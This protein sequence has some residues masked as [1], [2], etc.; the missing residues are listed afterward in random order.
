MDV[1]NFFDTQQKRNLL[2]L[3]ADNLFSKFSDSLTAIT[4]SGAN[5]WQAI[6]QQAPGTGSVRVLSN[7]SIAANEF[8]LFAGGRDLPG[9]QIGEGGAGGATSSGTIAWLQTVRGRGQAGALTNPPTDFAP[10]GGYVAFDNRTNW[11]FGTDIAAIQPTQQDFLTTATHELMHAMGFG[12]APSWNAWVS[13][14][15]F[16]G[17]QAVAAHD[18]GGAVPLDADLQHWRTGLTDGGVET[19]MDPDTSGGARKLPTRLDLAS[20]DDMGWELITPTIRVTGDHIYGDNGSY[21]ASIQVTGS[22]LGTIAVPTTIAITNVVPTLI[23]RSDRTQ[24]QD[25]EFSIIDI[26]SFSDPGFD[27]STAPTPTVETFTYRIDWGDGTPADTGTATVDRKGAVNLATLGSFD[28]RHIYENIGRYKV[29]VTVTDDDRGSNTDEFFIDVVGNPEISISLDRTS[30][31]ENAGTNAATLTVR[32]SGFDRSLPTVVTLSSS[33]TS[34]LKLPATVTII[35]GGSEAIVAIEAVDDTLLDGSISVNIQATAGAVRSNTVAMNVL[36][37]ETLDLLLTKSSIVE[38]AGLAASRLTISRSNTDR[39]SALT[40][41]LSSSDT[42]EAALPNTATIPAN[43][44]SATVDVQAVDD[45]LLDGLQNL[46]LTA[47]SA[48]YTDGSIALEVADHEP[49][50][51]AIQPA[52]L[53]EDVSNRKGVITVSLPAAAPVGG[54]QI[55]LSSSVANQINLPASVT[56]PAGARSVNVD[57]EAID[58]FRVEN[59]LTLQLLAAATGYVQA[60]AEVSITDNDL[61]I[62]RNPTNPLDTNNDGNIFAIDA[63][64][65]I[66]RLNL[67]GPGELIPVWTHLLAPI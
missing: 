24:T 58:D 26:G 11:Y 9:N 53:T 18:V 47:R 48:G 37:H 30:I 49:L 15:T 29:V 16:T 50:S 32:R 14:S 8:V 10:W 27:Q 4:P 64:L 41:Q 28:G 67:R 22:R 17:P 38:N 63:L 31:R 23:D 54:R 39:S 66:N 36:D 51:I 44:A 3:A 45:T 43:A 52:A 13:G 60:S 21:T 55:S 59:L 35:A 33:D 65:V 1:N 61:P 19:L 7:L 6:V 25:I 46:L 20:L 62:W 34:E 40:V 56:V 57:V 2:Q 42:T 5:T 12:V